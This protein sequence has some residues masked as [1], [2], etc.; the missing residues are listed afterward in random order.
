MAQG[1]EI[2]KP[3]IDIEDG[4][5]GAFTRD[6]VPQAKFKNGARIEKI[7]RETG[8]LSPL[9]TL[10][11]VLGSMYAP[12]VG[13]GYFVEWDRTPRLAVMVVEDKLGP[14]S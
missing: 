12:E 9:G 4:W 13:V 6:Q 14:A 11:T 8:D 5:V 7:L 1:I 2:M 10:G 3:N